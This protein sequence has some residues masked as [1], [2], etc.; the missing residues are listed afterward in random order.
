MSD[1][2]PHLHPAA[3]RA[4][5]ALLGWGVRDLARESGLG[6]DTISQFENGRTMREGN[7]T[8]LVEVFIAN[9]VE[10]LNGDAPGARLRKA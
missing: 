4:A 5:R 10:V 3:C 8:R 6:F 1:Q 7:K 9:G 2:L